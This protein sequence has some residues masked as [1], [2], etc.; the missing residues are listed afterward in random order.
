VTI[1]KILVSK[2][3]RLNYIVKKENA[4]WEL[5]FGDKQIII[6]YLISTEVEYILNSL[7]ANSNRYNSGDSC[8]VV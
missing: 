5:W 2:I 4:F 1:Y 3:S 8:K 6:N 7:I